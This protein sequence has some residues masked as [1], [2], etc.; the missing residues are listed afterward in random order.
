MGNLVFDPFTMFTSNNS[1]SSNE[2]VMNTL[3]VLIKNI[4]LLNL[5]LRKVFS[6]LFVCEKEV[7]IENIQFTLK[8][9]ASIV[10]RQFKNTLYRTRLQK[11]N[12][13]SQN[14]LLSDIEKETRCQLYFDEN[15]SLAKFV[16]FE[17]IVK[18]L[19]AKLRSSISY[20]KMFWFLIC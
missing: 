4:L 18:T 6:V 9:K 5:L 2:F 14:S 10:N 3:L 20:Q 19:L 8:A 12:K 7:E 11:A 15:L 17:E 16:N 13:Q 1:A